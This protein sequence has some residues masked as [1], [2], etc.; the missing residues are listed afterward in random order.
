MNLSAQAEALRNKEAQDKMAQGDVQR[1]KEIMTATRMKI[2][3]ESG[4]YVPRSPQTSQELRE[5]G[6]FRY[7]GASTEVLGSGKRYIPLSA[8]EALGRV[9]LEGIPKYGE[10]NWKDG[11]GDKRYQ[12]ERW[13]HADTHLRKWLE[14]DRTENHLAKVMWFC[15]TQIE[16][17]RMEQEKEKLAKDQSAPVDLDELFDRVNRHQIADEE[18]GDTLFPAASAAEQE[19]VVDTL[20]DIG[21]EVGT[22]ALL[23][24]IRKLMEMF[25]KKGKKKS[26]SAPPD[27]VV[28]MKKEKEQP[29][30]K[31]V[32]SDEGKAR[33]AAAQRKRWAK[34]RREKKAQ[35]KRG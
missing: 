7:G 26:T 28:E 20:K 16:L 10:H 19:G 15:A 18:A 11:A 30:K 29:R 24:S 1:R 6:E 3:S 23:A 17:E 31:R 9:F 14:G 5:I 35:E 34:V 22:E 2:M 33:I 25:G 21:L 12:A 27:G 13:E 32:L 8:L 4:L